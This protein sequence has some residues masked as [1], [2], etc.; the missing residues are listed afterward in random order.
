MR[1]E[2]EPKPFTGFSL[3]IRVERRLEARFSPFCYHSDET[4]G[5]TEK[6]RKINDNKEKMKG[7]RKDKRLETKMRNVRRKTNNAIIYI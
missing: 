7:T 4:I 3:L 5:N 6:E 1:N 2:S